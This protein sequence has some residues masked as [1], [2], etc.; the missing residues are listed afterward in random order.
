MKK[1]FKVVIPIILVLAIIACIGWYLFIY[2]RD[3]T[4]DILLNGARYFDDRGNH[5]ISGWFYD[6]AYI[7]ANNNDVVAIELAELHKADGNYTKAEYTLTRAI[8]D[9]GSADL[10]SGCRSDSA[11]CHGDH[12]AQYHPGHCQPAP[13][14]R[15]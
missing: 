6:Q 3:F 4:R 12:P 7:Q 11:G 13:G 1:F 9:G 15:G 5:T 2:D 14:G 8:S 10:Y